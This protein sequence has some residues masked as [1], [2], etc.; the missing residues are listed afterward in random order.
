M[1]DVIIKG[2]PEGLSPKLRKAYELRE[3][4]ILDKWDIKG[5]KVSAF[6]EK[7]NE[8]QKFGPPSEEQILALIG[9]HSKKRQPTLKL[10]AVSESVNFLTNI[11]IML[12]GKDGNEGND[13]IKELK[14]NPEKYLEAFTEQVHLLGGG[15]AKEG[16]P[17]F[18]G[19]ASQMI[20]Q[21]INPEGAVK[22]VPAPEAAPEQLVPPQSWQEVVDRGEPITDEEYRAL[23]KV[24]GETIPD[25]LTD[26]IADLHIWEE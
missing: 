11:A 26:A 4:A 7:V 21:T 17:A 1:D 2:I 5:K 6:R 9:V 15:T 13:A 18:Y 14:N 10:M 8:L 3:K 16:I 19:Y 23:K 12:T 22:S 24:L 20:G 25:E